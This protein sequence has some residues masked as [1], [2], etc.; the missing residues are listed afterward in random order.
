MSSGFPTR[1]DTNH[2]V[3][4]Q[5]MARGLKFRI[6]KVERLHYLCSKNKSADQLHC[7]HAFVFAYAK[8]RFSHDAA[9]IGQG[10]ATG[11]GIKHDLSRVMRKPAFCICQNKDADQLRRYREAD[12]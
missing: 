5:E 2:V 10:E 6:Y 7:N 3:Q 12:Q 4:P 1:S 11:K 9:H 8:S